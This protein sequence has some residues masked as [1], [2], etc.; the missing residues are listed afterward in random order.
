LQFNHPVKEL[1][2]VVKRD[3]FVTPSSTLTTNMG[4]QWFNFTDDWDTSLSAGYSGSNLVDPLSTNLAGGMP[5]V[6]AGGANAVL[7]PVSFESGVNPVATAKLQL[8]GHDRISERDGKYFSL[9]QPYQHHENVPKA[10]INVYSFALK[11]EEHQPSGTCN[12]SRID[13]AILQLNLTSKIGPSATAKI[14]VYA[15]SYNVL[16]RKDVK[17]ILKSLVRAVTSSPSDKTKLRETPKTRI[18]SPM[19]KIFD[20]WTTRSQ[21][22]ARDCLV[23][24]QRLYGFGSDNLSGI[25]YSPDPNLRNMS[26]RQGIY[27]THHV[28]IPYQDIKMY[29]HIS[30]GCK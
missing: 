29:K 23:M 30:E 28:S 1:V 7:L 19:V 18:T 6:A 11:P 21:S 15:V 24:I 14:A 13:N 4:K 12:M 8:N 25:R 22:F 2:F 5:G 9:V 10:G 26:K 16:K 20:D 27:R 17:M 3:D